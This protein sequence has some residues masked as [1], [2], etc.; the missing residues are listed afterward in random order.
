MMRKS[1][2]FSPEV[3][4][5]V[6]RM[7]F[8]A[9]DQPEVGTPLLVVGF[10]LGSHDTLH[11]MPLVRHAVIAVSFALRFKGQGYFPTDAR[12]H[13]GTSGAPVVMR[14]VEAGPALADLP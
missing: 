5:R 6:V 2:K 8:D 1:P 13:R 3:V 4:E 14:V 10:P 9:K 7:V 12:A 11:H